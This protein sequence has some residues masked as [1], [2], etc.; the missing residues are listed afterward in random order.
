MRKLACMTLACSMAAVTVSAE[1]GVAGKSTALTTVR[2]S[3]KTGTERTRF[4]V[5]LRAPVSS[6]LQTFDLTRLRPDGPCRKRPAGLREITYEK[7]VARG[8]RLTQQFRPPHWLGWCVGTYIGHVYL[9]QILRDRS[10]C[11]SEDPPQR[12]YR[13]RAVGRFELRVRRSPVPRRVRVPDVTG[14]NLRAAECMLASRRL[15]WR[16]VGEGSV[17]A[18]PVCWEHRPLASTWLVERQAPAG[19]SVRPGT[20]VRLR[21]RCALEDGQC[22]APRPTM[23][24]AR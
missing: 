16:F 22:P 9:T 7:A 14:M 21:I 19:G 17:R 1:A 13:S 2:V 24:D 10:E 8:V 4:V 12:C 5:S 3:P 6:D 11:R 20:V 23:E 18:H 15:R